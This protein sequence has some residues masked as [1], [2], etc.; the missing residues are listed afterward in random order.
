MQT[1]IDGFYDWQGGMLWLRMEAG[2]EAEML[3]AGIRHL[4]GGHATLVRATDAERHAIPVFEPQAA[5][6]AALTTR[7]REKFDPAGMFNLGRMG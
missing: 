1:G 6:V 2:P 5:A 4:G 3:R 7:I